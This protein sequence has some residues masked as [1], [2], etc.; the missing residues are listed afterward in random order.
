[1]PPKDSFGKSMDNAL[2]ADNT[3]G[4]DPFNH[5]AA[6]VIQTRDALAKA[7]RVEMDKRGQFPKLC[8]KE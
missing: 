6:G 1:M 3:G 2:L 5:Q 4:D 7:E 8:I